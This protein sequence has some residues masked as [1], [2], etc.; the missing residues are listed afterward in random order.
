MRD[1]LHLSDLVNPHGM[2]SSEVQ[3][4]DGLELARDIFN[5]LPPYVR[6]D[7]FS[8][9][10][11][12]FD[13]DFIMLFRKAMATGCM[14]SM[15]QIQKELIYDF[16]DYQNGINAIAGSVIAL[17]QFLC[18]ITNCVIPDSYSCISVTETF[19]PSIP[20]SGSKCD[21]NPATCTLD[22]GHH[23]RSPQI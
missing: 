2:D 7:S 4:S 10:K 12:I 22:Y 20:D 6:M 5:S 16:I 19:V 23:M 1:L 11:Y 3:I 15:S 17:D 8:G 13:Y 21:T 14:D 18:D 9:V